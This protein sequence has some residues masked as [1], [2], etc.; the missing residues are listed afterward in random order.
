M[1]IRNGGSRKFY[2]STVIMWMAILFFASLMAFGMERTTS[3]Y[4]HAEPKAK[5]YVCLESLDEYVR[6]CYDSDITS[7][8]PVERY[9]KAYAHVNECF[10][11][12]DRTD[13]KLHIYIHSYKKFVKRLMSIDM[14]AGS[15]LI[16]GNMVFHAFTYGSKQ[17]NALVI[18]AYEP[19]TDNTVIHELLH[20]YFDR[21]VLDGSLNNHE[22]IFSYTVHLEALFRGVLQEE[23]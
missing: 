2:L 23:Y 12:I 1:T 16:E 14:I 11:A 9:A 22:L 17:N 6:V 8:P 13:A 10:V 5:G 18:E 3:I 19:P 15:R 7:V 20:H 21:V 4:R